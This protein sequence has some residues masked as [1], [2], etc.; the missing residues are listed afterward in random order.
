MTIEFSFSRKHLEMRDMVRALAKNVIR[1]QAL[2]WDREGAI[3]EPFLRNMARVAT[4]VGSSAMTAG[5]GDDAPVN[6]DKGSKERM[7]GTLF[8]ALAAEEL[9]WGDPSLILCL[10][11]PGLGGPPVRSAGTPEQKKRFFSIFDG[12]A[13]EST[14]LRWGAYG[15]TEPSA[16][17]DVAAI[18]TSCRKDGAHWVLNG[19]KC[20]ITNGAKASWTVIFATIDPSLGRAGHRAF[21]VEKGTPGFMVG[22]IEEKMGLRA[23]ETAELVLEDCRVPAENLLGGEERYHSASS[24]GFMT[25]MKTFDNTRPVVGAMAIGIGRAAYDYARDFVKEHYV[26]SRSIPRYAAIAERLAKVGRELEAARGL[27][28]RAAWMGDAK[29]PNA[30]EAS[31]SKALA[32]QAAI[33]ACIDAIEICGA[34]GSIAK[35]HQLLE[36]WFRDIKVYDIFEGTGQIQRIVIAKRLIADLKSF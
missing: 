20:Y 5:L 14:P 19:R 15:L 3:P 34:E 9:A 16:G 31:M 22:R 29:Q 35:D 13:D 30:K 25:A 17:S 26:M 18:R 6:A 10:P 2:A 33:R 23:S 7:G 12:F 8:S 36:K 28:W 32:G 27:V 1:P 21:V 11:G 4:S 24:E